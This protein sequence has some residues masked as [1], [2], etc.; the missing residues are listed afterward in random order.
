EQYFKRAMMGGT[1]VPV[2]PLVCTG[3]VKYRGEAA[4]K[5]D[6]DNLRAA[7]ANLPHHALFMPSVAPSGVGT[8][9][10]YRSDEEFF[11]AVGAALHTECKSM[12]DEEELSQTRQRI[13]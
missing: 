8:N 1:A 2:V 10:Y 6:I 4:L 7:A 13:L 11:H 3:P 9:Q 5:R 12:L